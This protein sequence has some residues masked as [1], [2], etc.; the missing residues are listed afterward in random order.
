MK[1]S[2]LTLYS[3]VGVC[4]KQCQRKQWKQKAKEQG[5][6]TKSDNNHYRKAVKLGLPADKGI[7]KAKLLKRDGPLCAICGLMLVYGKDADPLGDLYWSIDHIVPLVPRDK[8]IVSP[9]HV[10]A[11]V[12]LAHRIC[13]SKKCNMIEVKYGNVKDSNKAE[14]KNIGSKENKTEAAG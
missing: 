7:T 1:R 13:N 14:V 4:S 6:Y 9:G 5:T 8:D 3:N 12:Q 10:W 2:G 11:N